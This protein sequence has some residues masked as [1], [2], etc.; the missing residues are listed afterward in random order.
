M[1]TEING[2]CFVDKLKFFLQVFGILYSF[3]PAIARSSNG[4]TSDFGSDCVGSNPARAT[5][6][7]A[8]CGVFYFSVFCGVPKPI[9]VKPLNNSMNLYLTS[10]NLK[11]RFAIDSSPLWF[12]PKFTF[13]FNPPSLWSH[14]LQ[15]LLVN[16]IFRDK[17][18]VGKWTPCKIRSSMFR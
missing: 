15:E 8:T 18:C 6:N 7:P 17:W 4:R 10:T 3:A 11:T 12:S 13:L 2:R 16:C 14:W 9:S 1:L 5:Q